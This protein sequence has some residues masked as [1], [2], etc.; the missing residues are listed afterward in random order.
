MPAV[1]GMEHGDQPALPSTRYAGWYEGTVRG[2]TSQAETDSSH[3]ESVGVA[4]K[5]YVVADTKFTTT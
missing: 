1:H 3:C 2:V 5:A 4:E